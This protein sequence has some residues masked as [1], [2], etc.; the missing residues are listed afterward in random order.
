LR[1]PVVL[2]ATIIA[3]FWSLMSGTVAISALAALGLLEI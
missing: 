1:F 3:G 2:T